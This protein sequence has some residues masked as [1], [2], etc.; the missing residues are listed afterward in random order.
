MSEPLKPCSLFSQ[1]HSYL[2]LAW[3]HLQ[4]PYKSPSL[5][6]LWSSFFGGCHPRCASVYKE[7]TLFLQTYLFLSTWAYLLMHLLYFTCFIY[8]L[9]WSLQGTLFLKHL[10]MEETI[11]HFYGFHFI[12]CGYSLGLF[13]SFPSFI[14][15]IVWVPLGFGFTIA[16]FP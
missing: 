8:S 2:S 13:F 15:L 12:S 1:N 4:K 6:N 3:L 7:K 16:I 9:Y 14:W 5:F 11:S 10:L